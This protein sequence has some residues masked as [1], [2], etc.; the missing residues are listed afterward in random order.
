MKVH[1]KTDHRFRRS[2]HPTRRGRAATRR[3]MRLVVGGLVA[4][5]VT[6]GSYRVIDRL[7][8]TPYLLVADV[9][10]EGNGRLS[11][12]E[13][14]ALMPGLVGSNILTLDLDAR[15]RQLTSASWLQEGTLRRVLPAT[16]EVFVRERWPVALARFD[17]HLFLVD[18]SG[19]V[20]DRYGPR[21]ADLDL[22]I[23]DGLVAVP[24]GEQI[25]VERMRLVIRVLEALSDRPEV[26]SVVSQIDVSDPRNAVVLLEDDPALLY[27]GRERFLERLRSY[28]ELAP[29]LRDEV[30]E[31]DYVDLRFEPQVVIGPVGAS[32]ATGRGLNR[33]AKAPGLAQ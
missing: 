23:V 20:I 18:G 27:L 12:E 6:A 33:L 21:F 19:T 26:L 28:A 30:A 3:W 16:I 32:T 31:I 5:G 17:R 25:P 8:V 10:V 29:R 24:E 1:A 9:V 2:R 22:P 14:R 11:D 4:A 7:L 13:V 15:R